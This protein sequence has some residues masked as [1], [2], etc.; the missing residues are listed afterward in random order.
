MALGARP[1]YIQSTFSQLWNYADDIW[2]LSGD[3]SM[4]YNHY[5]KRALFVS[6]YAATELFMLSDQSDNFGETWAFLARR[7]DDIL[8]VGQKV[9]FWKNLTTSSLGGVKDILSSFYP[10]P[11]NVDNNIEE[12]RRKYFSSGQY[13]QTTT[14][15]NEDKK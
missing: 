4:D 7:I 3:R 2:V 1:Q 5:T 9:N 8:N 11:Q 15:N 12:I 14:N 13:Y 10:L 6:V